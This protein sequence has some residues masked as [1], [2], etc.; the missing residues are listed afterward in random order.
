MK[1]KGR[2]EWIHYSFGGHVPMLERND[3]GETTLCGKTARRIRATRDK[4]GVTCLG[5]IEGLKEDSWFC[6]EHGFIADED[7]R[8]D[9]TCD[10]CG[11]RVE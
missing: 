3:K 1:K 5:C 4:N 6:E 9:E 10:Y 11:A 2:Q 8:N 7:V